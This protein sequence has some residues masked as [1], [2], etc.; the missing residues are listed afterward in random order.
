[1]VQMVTQSGITVAGPNQPYTVVKNIP[2]P[3]PGPKEALVKS[4]MV[5]INPVES[6]MQHSGVLVT[7]WPAI[8]G[9]DGCGVVLETG[10]RCSRLKKGDYVFSCMRVGQNKYTPFQETYLV[11]EELVF[12]KNTGTSVEQACTIGVGLLTAG[13]AVLSGLDMTMPE[14]GKKAD[15]KDSWVVVMGG[16]G[17]VG[18]FACQLARLCGY[19][20]LA[21]SS[22]SKTSIATNAGATATFNCRAAPEDQLADIK[23]ITGGKFGRVFDASVQAYN[24]AIKALETCSAE[25]TKYFSSV[26]DWS[27]MKT[28]ASIKEYRVH[29]GQIGREQS[30]VGK[31]VTENIKSWIPTFEGFLGTGALKPLDYQIVPGMG[32]EKVI[33]GVADLE[34]G[35][36]TKKIVVK[37][38]DE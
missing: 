6:L 12:E 23:K 26:D 2:R 28:P 17:N 11:D 7:E 36:S 8:L 30:P 38:Q 35:K 19:K 34:G 18:Q 37:V 27:E 24:L 33:E 16:S 29:L 13:L 14:P 3:T 25:T 15:A 21:S 32:W 10:D 31:T 1:M 4:L 22:P 20:V 9:T 5:G